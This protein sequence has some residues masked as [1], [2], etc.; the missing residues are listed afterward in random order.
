MKIDRLAATLTFAL[1]IVTATDIAAAD[2]KVLSIPF[3]APMEQIGP[4]FERQTGH[5]LAITYAPSAPS[6]N[7]SKPTSR[8][9]SS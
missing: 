9:T 5:R 1:T 3:K 7:R 8:S 6:S 4:R 2:I